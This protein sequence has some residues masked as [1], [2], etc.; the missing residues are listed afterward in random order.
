MQALS[1]LDVLLVGLSRRARLL[2][3]LV[4]ENAITERA[5]L[6]AALERGQPVEPRWVFRHEA[7]ARGLFDALE[8]ARL[9]AEAL[10]PFL[11]DAYASRLDELELDLLILQALSEPHGNK[12]ARALGKRRFGTG[13]RVAMGRPLDVIARDW[14]AALSHVEE[15]PRTLPADGPGSLADAMRR[16][17]LAADLSLEVRVEPRLAAGAATGDRTIF[18]GDRRFGAREAR[19]LVAHEVLG[20]AVAADNGRRWPL[21]LFSAGSADAFADQEGLALSLEEDAGA[22]DDERRRTLALRVLSSDW[23]HDGA[24]FVDVAQ[25]LSRDYAL[26]PAS[27]VAIAE[28]A[29]RGNGVARDVAYLAGYVRVRAAR[30][31]GLPLEALRQGRISLAI[32]ASLPRFVELDLRPSSPPRA[33]DTRAVLDAAFE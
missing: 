27:T 5:R 7:P 21:A 1:E 11:G 17:A 4:P 15:E 25:R 20:H 6:L 13:Q 9:R 18:V 2:P 3:A 28:R 12:R 23:V 31:A 32:A 24:S 14:L 16:A 10:P 29:C 30:D 19:R 26:S 22:L 33:P 8:A